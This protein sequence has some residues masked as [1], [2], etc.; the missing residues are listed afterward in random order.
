MLAVKPTRLC[1]VS[2]RQC[3]HAVVC[4]PCEHAYCDLYAEPIYLRRMP[5]GV[6]VFVRCWPCVWRK[7]S[8]TP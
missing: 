4:V 2:G 6:L 1:L 3:P 8:A 5:N 7:Y